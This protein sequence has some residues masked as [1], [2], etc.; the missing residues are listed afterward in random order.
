MTGSVGAYTVE[1][2]APG[3]YDVLLDGRL[4]AALT[5]GIDDLEEPWRLDLLAE[6]S[7]SEF[8]QPFTAQSHA[9]NSYREALYWLGIYKK[10]AAQSSN[11]PNKSAR[12]SPRYRARLSPMERYRLRLLSEQSRF[13]VTITGLNGL[14]RRGFIAS[15]ERMDDEGRAEWA[16]TD[17]GRA[18]LAEIE[19]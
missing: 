14:I 9:F 3:S 15:T 13:Y 5:R 11:L 12:A 18:A 17:T 8:P 16:I 6:T 1:K 4:I 10:F 19:S 7:P 2:L